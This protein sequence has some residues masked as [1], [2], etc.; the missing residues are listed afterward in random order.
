MSPA[1]SPRSSALAETPPPPR[2]TK[3]NRNLKSAPPPARRSGPN[4]AASITA[5]RSAPSRPTDVWD[6]RRCPASAAAEKAPAQTPP[7]PAQKA[8]CVAPNSA[9][10][11]R[12]ARGKVPLAGP[13]ASTPCAQSGSPRQPPARSAVSCTP[14]NRTSR[15]TTKPVPTRRNPA[16]SSSGRA[17][18]KT[19]AAPRTD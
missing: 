6:P 16:A 18:S 11:P 19:R 9:K 15:S 13:S 17:P 8:T 10:A 3:P 1:A 7:P 14:D 2:D 12:T 4:K 5:P